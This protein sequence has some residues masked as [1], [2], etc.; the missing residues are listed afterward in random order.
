M[1]LSQGLKAK[2]SSPYVWKQKLTA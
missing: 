1:L 2:H